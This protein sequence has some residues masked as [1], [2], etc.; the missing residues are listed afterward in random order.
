MTASEATTSHATPPPAAPLKTPNSATSTQFATPMHPS[1]INQSVKKRQTR[2]SAIAET[3]SSKQL[4][5]DRVK[6]PVAVR[7]SPRVVKNSIYHTY[8][9]L[10]GGNLSLA[11]AS[12]AMKTVAKLFGSEWSIPNENKSKYEENDEEEVDILYKLPTHKQINKN[13][14]LIE[15]YSYKCAGEELRRQKEAGAIICHA[16]DSTTRKAVGKFAV[17]TLHVNKDQVIPLPILN[18]SSES[19]DNVSDGVISG[20]EILAAASGQST[21]AAYNCID[22]HMTDAT[23]HNKSIASNIAGKLN[24]D[25]PAGQIFCNVHTTLGFDSEMKNI[26]NEVE[27]NIGMQNIF[28]GFAMDLDTKGSITLNFVRWTLNLFGPDKIQKPWNLHLLFLEY[29][30]KHNKPVKLFAMKDARFGNLS[31]SAAIVIYHWNDFIKFLA[32][33][34]SADIQQ[35]VLYGGEC[36]RN[37]IHQ[38]CA[39]CDRCIWDSSH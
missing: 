29:M 4:H 24:I 37:R 7:D 39:P 11:E 14:E 21:D 25:T 23:A 12:F 9:E 35:L 36:P 27:A 16:T 30:T 31:K 2:T 34:R 18:I 28:S 17:S 13:V 38:N 22:V 3:S 19:T 10:L 15:A 1:V 5:F 26:V 32:C 8:A 20:I 33:K 6:E